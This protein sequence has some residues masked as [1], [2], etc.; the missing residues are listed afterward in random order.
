VSRGR[1][2]TAGGQQCGSADRRPVAGGL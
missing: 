1:S 2:T